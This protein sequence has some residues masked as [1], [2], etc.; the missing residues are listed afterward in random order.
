MEGVPTR[1]RIAFGNKARAGKD[2]AGAYILNKYGGER[3]SFAETLYDISYDV[4]ASLGLPKQKNPALLQCLGGG[5]RARLYPEVWVDVVKRKILQTDTV[6][7]DTN[8]VVTDM[9]Y[10]NEMRMLKEH[11]FITVR[12]NRENRPIDRDPNHE[13][14]IALDS[15]EFDYTINN[16]GTVEELYEKIEKIIRAR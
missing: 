1:I 16:D 15:A 14:E 8:L 3:L 10:P 12:V 6:A 13:S 4:L 2:T 9:R 7:P 5:L 11:G